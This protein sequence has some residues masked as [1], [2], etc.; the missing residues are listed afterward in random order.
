MEYQIDYNK[1]YI[2][3]Y[4]NLDRKRKNVNS[5]QKVKNLLEITKKHNQKKIILKCKHNKRI[6]YLD[7]TIENSI[8][9]FKLLSTLEECLK[10][11]FKREEECIWLYIYLKPK[12]YSVLHWL[13]SNNCDIFEKYQ[14]TNK[15][16]GDFL[17][18][19]VD[20]FNKYMSIPYFFTS[21]EAKFDC[22]G[23]SIDL[24]L[25][26]IFKYEKTYYEKYGFEF[27][28]DVY[29]EKDNQNLIKNKNDYEN[30]KK[31]IKNIKFEELVKPLYYEEREYFDSVINQ[32][33]YTLGDVM[34]NVLENDCIAYHDLLLD[35]K[36]HNRHFKYLIEKIEDAKTSYVKKYKYNQSKKN[37]KYK[38]KTAK[39]QI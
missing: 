7:F 22:E 17:M 14:I 30:T 29:K 11:D 32:N 15:K 35:L 20:R 1:K 13:N 19:F 4:F 26:Q 18:S 38:K 12:Y 25:S 5:K 39:K 27:D 37:K 36:K 28:M 34:K 8:L 6:F 9:S 21:D 23:V 3:L 33:S 31:K 2:I 16:R 10:E 24:S